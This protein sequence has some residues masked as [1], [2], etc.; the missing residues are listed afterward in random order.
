MILRGRLIPDTETPLDDGKTIPPP[1]RAKVRLENGKSA[2]AIIKRMSPRETAIECYCSVL[3]AGWNIPTPPVAL[4]DDGGDSFIFA[5]L[6][7]TYPSLKKQFG[8]TTNMGDR[9]QIA[10]TFAAGQIVKTWEEVPI[11]IAADEAIKNYDRNL[12]NIG[13]SE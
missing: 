13:Y 3:I 11:V 5:S 2:Q 7:T 8:I 10:R 1:M 12:G 6:D 4:I 9:E